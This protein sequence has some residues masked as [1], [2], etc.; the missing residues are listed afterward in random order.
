MSS[1]RKKLLLEPSRMVEFA[2]DSPLE[3]NGF[4]LPVPRESDVLRALRRELLGQKH[5]VR[6]WSVP[7]RPAARDASPKSGLHPTLC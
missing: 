1:A 2:A 4:E 7:G 3:R 5:P 6:G